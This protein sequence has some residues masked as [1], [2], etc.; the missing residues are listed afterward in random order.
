MSVI[1]RLS[2]GIMLASTSFAHADF[3]D[4]L[5]KAYQSD[6]PLASEIASHQGCMLVRPLYGQLS[7]SEVNESSLG[8]LTLPLKVKGGSVLDVGAGESLCKVTDFKPQPID[9]KDEKKNLEFEYGSSFRSDT[10]GSIKATLGS[11]LTLLNFEAADLSTT[12]IGFRGTTRTYDDD[13]LAQAA[14]DIKKHKKVCTALKKPSYIISR[15]CIG[16]VYVAL[17]ASQKLTLN[18]LDFKFANLA[19]GLKAEWVRELGGTLES[20]TSSSNVATPANADSATPPSAAE[21]KNGFSAEIKTPQG[22]VKITPSTFDL[23][24]PAGIKEAPPSSDA[25]Q[26]VDPSVKTTSASQPAKGN[27]VCIKS[28]VYRTSAPVIY[29]IAMRNAAESKKEAYVK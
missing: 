18:A 17:E 11:W 16:Y 24:L 25:K 19:V 5:K 4:D 8:N 7:G 10:S 3:A 29:G 26:K 21:L 23:T 12:K 28:V 9:D 6:N 20:C 13:S 2:L 27:T 22:N 15:N 1:L 14:G